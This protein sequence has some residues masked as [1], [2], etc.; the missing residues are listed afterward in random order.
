MKDIEK[1]A[2]IREFPVVFE[3]HGL[4]LKG[5]IILPKQASANEPVPG[6]VLCHGFGAAYRVMEPA[7]RMMA[8]Q[9]IASLIFDFRGHGASEGAMDGKMAE[10]VV[11][12]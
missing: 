4:Q 1:S 12:A 10:D 5:K 2:E 7:A 8:D 6:A 3:S 9:G 11:D